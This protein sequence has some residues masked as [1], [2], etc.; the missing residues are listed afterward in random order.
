MSSHTSSGPLP[1]TLLIGGVLA[2]RYGRELYDLGFPTAVVNNGAE[3]VG[4]VLGGGFHVV[5]V[6]TELT[7]M[8][9]YDFCM[10]L[11]RH[12]QGVLVVLHGPLDPHYAELLVNTGLVAYLTGR[13][14]QSLA[15]TIA[16]RFGIP[17]PAATSTQRP[18]ARDF[19]APHIGT[20]LSQLLHTTTAPTLSSDRT[21]APPEPP[22]EHPSISFSALDEEPLLA[23]QEDEVSVTAPVDPRE[24]ELVRLRERLDFARQ[25]ADRARLERD[26]LRALIDSLEEERRTAEKKLAELSGLRAQNEA[27]ERMVSEL[28]RKLA[29]RGGAGEDKAR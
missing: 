1:A 9:A 14:N 10:S 2:Q 11:L 29:A 4:A 3:A 25:E 8:S 6:P 13:D 26:G 7:D 22:A 12:V 16:A 21:A 18:A 27:L 5:V 24:V 23:V 19:H 17:L 15:A 20:P 28:T